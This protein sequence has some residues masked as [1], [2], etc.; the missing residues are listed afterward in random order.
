MT[1]TKTVEVEDLKNNL[2]AYLRDVKRGT[3]ILVADRDRVIAELRDLSAP[4]TNTSEDNPVLERWVRE[5]KVR[6]PTRPRG[7]MES[8]GLKSSAGTAERLLD[9][10]RRERWEQV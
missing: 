2:R 9:E 7:P 4:Y 5:G 3:R 1:N 6:I 10:A 8:T